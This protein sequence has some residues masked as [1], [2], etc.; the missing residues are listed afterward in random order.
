[1]IDLHSHLLPGVDDGSRTVAQ[2]AA[3]LTRL[4]EQGT[5]AVCL[6]PH[7]L[8]SDAAA[9]VPPAH[10]QAWEALAPAVP[11][12]MTLYRGAEV[13]MDRPLEPSVGRDRLVTIHRSRYL[14]IEFPR[15]VTAHAVEQAL[16]GVT[17]AGLVPLVAHPERYQCVSVTLARHWKELGAVLQVDGPTLLSSRS[18]GERARQLVA[19]G[20]ADIAAADNHGDERS[21]RPVQDT[22]V[23]MAGGEQ[24]E[25][26]LTR[27]PRAIVEDRPLD[28][29]PPLSWRRS[30]VDRL[31]WLLDR[32]PPDRP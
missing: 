1:M 32:T 24:A 11:E 18:R 5:D 9:G 4:V 20:L 3:V 30:I 7:L 23:D 31:R 29:V 12:G 28:P 8:A 26:L 25:L 13:M 21:L 27:N 16:L 17:G 2:S 10:E 22:L 15:L 14:L 19:A 6:T